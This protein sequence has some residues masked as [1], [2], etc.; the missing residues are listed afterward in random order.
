MADKP[1]VTIR[2]GA[3]QGCIKEDYH[4]KPYYNFQGI[5]YA[6]PPIDDLRFKAPQPA[7][8]WTGVRNATME[9]K[10]CFSRHM[11]LR[12]PSG[13]EDCLYLNIYTPKLPESNTSLKPVM[14]FIHGGGF[15]MGSG[16]SE[17][18]GAGYF[19]PEDVVLV[20]IN[21]RL[22]LL[23][24][25]SFDDVSLDIPGNAGLKDQVM[26]LRWV[27][28]N[29]GCFGG[30]PNNVTIF[31]E[32]AGSA[33]V[34]YLIL[35]PLAK[36]LFH[37]AILQSGT[38]FSPWARGE[39]S[40]TL[41]AASLG[42]KTTHER[43]IYEI[44][45]KMTK[46]ELLDLQEKVPDMFEANF[47]RPFGPV[48][49]NVTVMSPFLTKDPVDV[50]LSGDFNH[51]PMIIGFNSREGMLAVGESKRMGLEIEFMSNFQ[52]AVPHLMKIPPNSDLS[53]KLAEKIK[54]F[55]YG[56][57]IPSLNNINQ[58]YLMQGD[59]FFVWSTYFA[60]KNHN[61]TSSAPVYFYRMSSDTNLNLYKKL[62][63]IT[64]A[65]ACHGDDIG[66]LFTNTLT[67]PLIRNST[68]EITVR[69]FVKLWATFAKT[70][71]PNPPENS[72]INIFWKPVEKKKFHFLEIGD[73]LT[74]GVNPEQERMNF[75]EEI[76]A[77]SSHTSK[78]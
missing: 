54:S 21:Y 17:L 24:F 7:E 39:K 30:D 25:L 35:S 14:F 38:A 12:T 3:L 31:G 46:E 56:S 59:N 60:V 40:S 51:V 75:W 53:M 22:G 47:V 69:R 71:N 77:L 11:I 65:G 9:G 76:F 58:Y 43:E 44:L 67:T 27:K 16:N 50:L 64:N 48:V 42:L 34:H 10:H 57:E 41:L 49:E 4:G 62:L 26:A 2:N 37:H 68:E 45:Q 36:G 6:K 13:S 32:S 73:N 66:Y 70:G 52:K 5:P 20:T 8:S 78:L 55:Y 28:E 33:S 1:V 29:I 63:Q 23:G 74:V 15:T 72:L 19:M 61:L 18:Y